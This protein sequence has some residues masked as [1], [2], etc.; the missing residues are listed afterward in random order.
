M[1]ETGIIGLMAL[2]LVIVFGGLV[3]FRS[4]KKF[5]INALVGIAILI[6]ANNI[7]GLG[8]GYSWPVILIC[9][10]G[11]A[12]GAMLI[13]ALHYIGIAVTFTPFS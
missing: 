9:A 4:M 7:A 5:L 3:L 8:I 6:V 1:I 12:L 13:I 2:A 10:I 11:G